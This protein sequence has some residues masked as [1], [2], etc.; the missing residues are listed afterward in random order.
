MQRWEYMTLDFTKP[1]QGIDDLNGLGAAGWEVVTM[2][3]TWGVSEWRFA[4]PILLLKRPLV[5]EPA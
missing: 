2:S 5:D 1:K 3:T 4:H